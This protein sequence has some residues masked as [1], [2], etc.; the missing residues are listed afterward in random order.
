MLT[1]AIMA[2]WRTRTQ[3]R[4][5]F[6]WFR[7]WTLANY[8]QSP[9]SIVWFYENRGVDTFR[10]ERYRQNLVIFHCQ[11]LIH[12]KV[13]HA[14]LSTYSEFWF[15]EPDLPKSWNMYLHKSSQDLRTS[16][17][18][19]PESPSVHKELC[20]TSSEDDFD[21]YKFPINRKAAVPRILVD[22]CF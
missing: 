15:V 14:C 1:T 9:R 6:G 12:V 17:E 5:R 16:P 22:K 20:K 10:P 21:I 8:W 4:S 3:G 18:V 7:F 19:S 2:P 13:E 11:G